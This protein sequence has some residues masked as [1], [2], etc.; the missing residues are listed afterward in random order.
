M[1]FNE[2][3][4][5]DQLVKNS[6]KIGRANNILNT[7]WREKQDFIKLLHAYGFFCPDFYSPVG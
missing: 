3:N 7:S 4:G 2:F 5:L 6:K 1:K